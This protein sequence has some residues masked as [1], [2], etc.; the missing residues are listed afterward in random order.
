M[1][2]KLIVAATATLLFSNTSLFAQWTLSSPDVA[3]SSPIYNVH[4]GLSS[5]TA[6]LSTDNSV[7]IDPVSSSNPYD[8]QIHRT[9]YTGTGHAFDAPNIVDISNTDATG[10]PYVTTSFLTLDWLGKLTLAKDALIGGYT[11]I[12]TLANAG[13]GRLVTVDANGKLD[14]EYPPTIS[15]AATSNTISISNGATINSTATLPNWADN[16][17]IAGNSLSLRHGATTLNTVTI[18][19]GADNLGNHTATTTL[20]MNSHGIANAGN[21]YGVM[22]IGANVSNELTFSTISDNLYNHLGVNGT[23]SGTYALY[24]SGDTYT[25][26]TY[27]SSDKRFKKNVKAVELINDELFKVKSYS[28]NFRQNEFQA[29]HFDNKH[30]FGFLAQDVKEIFPD[31]VKMDD[32][33]YY[34]INYV[35]FIP[36]LLQSLKE[37]DQK[38]K[39][40]ETR[41][42]DL[43][44]K[45]GTTPT[46]TDNGAGS[47]TAKSVLYQ[48]N[49]NPFS[50]ETNI[51]YSIVGDYKAA[52]I[53][54]YDLNGRQLQRITIAAGSSQVTVK[55]LNP[56]MYVYSLIVDGS[57]ID[58]KKMVMLG[59]K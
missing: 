46:Y 12:S 44:S 59:D 33:G 31:L 16:L 15:Y 53:G 54:V 14:D 30:H 13:G 28:Y 25:S 58:S 3:T 29:R 37:E 1:N 40:L 2:K 9:V 24:V 23:G 34:A 6:K 35:E 19:S 26:G 20:N 45:I 57:L 56:G 4:I 49:P 21:I 11:T 8:L 38:V 32:S 5:G 50:V 18:P 10:F 27:T 55:G 48:N 47:T 39:D 36:L 17:S 43:E 7:A 41:I 22:N 52:F 51:R 42:A